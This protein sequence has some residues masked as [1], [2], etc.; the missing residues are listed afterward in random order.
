MTTD[1]GVNVG[2]TMTTMMTMTD[3]AR[4]TRNAAITTTTMTTGNRPR[5]A[6]RF[7]PAKVGMLMVSISLWIYLGTYALLALFLLIAWIGASIPSGLMIVT[8]LLGLGN[9]IVALIGLGFCIA[10]PA[11][12]RGLAIAATAVAAVH[13]AMCFV[14]AN[15]TKSAY[16][17]YSSIPAISA[18][19]KFERFTDLMKKIEKE[20]DPKRKE[21]LQKELRDLSESESGRNSSSFD[22]DRPSRRS[23]DD[24]RWQD[25][26]TLMPYS[27]QLI[28]VLSYR[29][30]G[31]SDYVLSLLSGLI[32]VARLVLIVLLV[33]SMA[34][35]AKDHD[36]A[37]RSTVAAF[38]AG[39]ATIAAMIVIVL[40]M[41]ILDS[42]KSTSV[43]SLEEAQKAAKGMMTWAI[44]A[45]LLV[46][47]IHIG[48]LVMPAL[49]ALQTKNAAARRGR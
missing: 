49:L 21:S 47:A 1:R 45:E 36:A 37:D 14:V 33:G 34:R 39:G 2:A 31:F 27:D 7:G 4:K 12:S 26:A 9:W 22:D 18:M 17:E 10:G 20:T 28:G 41:V 44:L 13:L 38:I 23:A 8:G 42:N 46:Y 32:E 11:R 3:R 30:K 19:N 6:A 24:M 35:A 5:G 48:S 40:V 25:L 16:F 43:K 15:N 29:S